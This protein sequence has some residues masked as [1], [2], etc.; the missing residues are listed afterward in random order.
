MSGGPGVAPREPSLEGWIV[1]VLGGTGLIGSH[2]VR[3][4]AARGA[5]VRALVRETSR[6][7]T[8]EGV[9]GVRFV[10]GDLTDAGSLQEAVS[11]C[12]LLVHSAATYA[13]RAF[14]RDRQ[15]RLAR[16]TVAN[17]LDAC[18]THRARQD[19]V[20]WGRVPDGLVRMVYVSSPTTVAPPSEP[21]RMANE[22]DTYTEPPD[23]AP[24][25]HVK[26]SME[27]EM[28]TAAEA[29]GLPIVTVVPTFV[30]D[31]YDSKPT[32]GQLILSVA[33]KQMPVLL[34]GEIN[35]VPGRDVGEG[36]ALAATR[37][38]PG[39]RYILGGENM[40]LESLIGRIAAATGVTAPKI[41]LPFWMAEGVAWISE[42]AAVVTGKPPLLPING[43]H[44]LRRSRYLDS[45]RAARD[46]GWTAGPVDDA[47]RRAVA[48]FRER[49]ML[50]V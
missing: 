35:V 38:T 45:S 39:R 32:T 36:I 21:G 31:E 34:P 23:W 19:P 40:S 2:T 48:W 5:E 15:M 50:K 3:S 16:Q 10:T 22:S 18:R 41:R 14:E 12:H 24:Y 17:V 1:L 28:M 8:I 49:G 26:A 47:I 4:F 42:L 11:G 29:E 44:M 37:G 46:L 33:H 25:F 20:D 7:D 30:L 13:T 9:A 43:L 6:R 27:S